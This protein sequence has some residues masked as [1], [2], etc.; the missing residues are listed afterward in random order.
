MCI[1]DLQKH[2]G[3]QRKSTHTIKAGTGGGKPGRRKIGKAHKTRI[4][5]PPLK[6]PLPF[7]NNMSWPEKKRVDEGNSQEGNSRLQG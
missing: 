6:K 1:G 5:N 2:S 7:P 4:H 3:F